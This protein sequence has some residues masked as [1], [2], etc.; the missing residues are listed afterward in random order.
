MWLRRFDGVAACPISPNCS[1]PTSP[2][3]KSRDE[4]GYVITVTGSRWHDHGVTQ[5]SAQQ[6]ADE[7]LGG[8]AYLIDS[9]RTRVPTPD[10]AAGL[11]LA[12][13]L[14][15]A[16]ELADHHPD[17]DLRRTRVDI[18]LTSH[19]TGAVTGRDIRMART[20]SAL[21]ADAGLTQECASVTQIGFVLDSPAHSATSPF[22]AAVLQGEPR[23]HHVADPYGVVPLVVFQESGTQEPRQRWHPDI[24]V[25]PA[26]TQPRLDAALTAGGTLVSDAAAPSFWVLADPEGNRVCLCTWQERS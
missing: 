16:A 19:D 11:T 22:W 8:W 7:E 25:D 10:F 26:Q 18:R 9:L 24:W 1:T 17:I 12:N 13:A 15:A 23:E 2:L 3:A 14:G 5:L 4:V 20:I 6:I 21:I